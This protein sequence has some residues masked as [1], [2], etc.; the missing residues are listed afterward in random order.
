MK[1]RMLGWFLACMAVGFPMA[2]G[3][4]PVVSNVRA[5]QRANTKLVDITYDLADEDGTSYHMVVEVRSN[6]TPIRATALTGDVG[7]TLVAPGAGKHIVWDA[8]VDWNGFYS[9]EMSVIVT[10]E[11]EETDRYMVVD[12]SGGSTATSYPVSFLSRVPSGG[13]TDEYK[14]TKLVLRKLPPGTFMMGSPEWELGCRTNEVLHSVT[15][16]QPFYIGVF[17]VTQKQWFNVM[18]VSNTSSSNYRGDYRPACYVSYNMIRGASEGAR[19]PASNGVDSTSMLYRVRTKTGLTFDL[20]TEAQWEYACRAGT[21]TALNSGKDLTNATNCPNMAEVGRYSGNQSDGKG[22]YT[23]Y[24]TTVGSYLPNA[25][26]LYDMHGNVV[27]WCLDWYGAY[28]GATT[29]P[30]GPAS[31]SDRLLRGGSCYDDARYC[32]SAVR[33]DCDPSIDGQG[34]GFRLVALPAVQ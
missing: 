32:R 28:G 16:T 24:H 14:T 7:E 20:P 30:T 4:V 3:G 8:G 1:M 19:W 33:D 17:E 25:W 6:G 13:W 11:E 12:L 18:G 23:S 21:T 5:A 10:A 34:L 9:E 29:D 31:G 27:E 26:G 15:L 2:R 22:G